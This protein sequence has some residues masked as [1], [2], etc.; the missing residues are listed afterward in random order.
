MDAEGV[1]LVVHHTVGFHGA[2]GVHA[3]EDTVEDEP[4]ER[5]DFGR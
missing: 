1:S 2:R 4:Q 3:L 5:V